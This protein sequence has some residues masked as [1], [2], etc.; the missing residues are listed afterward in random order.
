MSCGESGLIVENHF[1]K[2]IQISTD[3]HKGLPFVVQNGMKEQII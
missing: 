1:K 3:V 2:C